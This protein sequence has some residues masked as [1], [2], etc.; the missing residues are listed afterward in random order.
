MQEESTGELDQHRTDR[1]HGHGHSDDGTPT[2][3]GDEQQQRPLQREHPG[4]VRLRLRGLADP[5]RP[6]RSEPWT[7]HRSPT[8]LT[9]VFQPACSTAVTSTSAATLVGA[10]T[11]SS[12]RGMRGD[13]RAGRR[14]SSPRARGAA[15]PLRS[16]AAN[17]G[18]VVGDVDPPVGSRLIPT[19]AV[20]ARSPLSTWR[21][22]PETG[23]NVPAD[24]ALPALSI[25]HSW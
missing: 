4:Q 23:S 22:V 11:G 16:G 18:V 3:L 6:G 8:D 20:F 19:A 7:A 5:R 14:L 24:A 13:D 12:R 2:E 21:A 17:T 9:A 15:Q 10:S 1:G 25:S